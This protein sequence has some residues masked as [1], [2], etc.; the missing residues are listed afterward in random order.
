MREHERR[1]RDY[2]MYKR[3]SIF[4][5]DVREKCEKHIGDCTFLRLRVEE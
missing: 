2:C 5:V 4:V 3:L 1:F